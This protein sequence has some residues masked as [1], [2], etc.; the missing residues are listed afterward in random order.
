MW[1]RKQTLLLL[2]AVILGMVF[3]IAWPLFIIQMLSSAISLIAV[4]LYRHRTVQASVCLAAV[5]VN[6]AWYVCLA[7]MVNNGS[8]PDELPLTVCLPLIAAILC[9]LARKAIIADE[10]LVRSVDRIR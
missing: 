6:L 3:F 2:I 9:F 10:K 5:C 7:V 1:Q 4:Y 8:L